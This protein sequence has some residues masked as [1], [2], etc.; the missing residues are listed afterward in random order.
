MARKFSSIAWRNLARQISTSRTC[1]ASDF[2][3]ILGV[4][5]TATQAE[6]K[7]AYFELS[8]LYHPDKNVGSADNITKFRHITTAYEVLG[9]YFKS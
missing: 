7:M 8:K 4:K 9:E 3:A 2:Y 5:P 1:F 6:I